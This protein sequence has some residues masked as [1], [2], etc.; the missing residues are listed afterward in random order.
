MASNSKTN[1]E[2]RPFGWSTPRLL[3]TGLVL[4]FGLTLFVGAVT[5]TAGFN[6]YNAN[7][8]GN[9][10]FRELADSQSELIVGTQTEQYD[11]VEPNATTVFILSPE[12]EY[13]T[14]ATSSVQEFVEA[15]GTVVVADNY[16]PHGN[17][18]LLEIGAAAQFDGRVLRDERHSFRSP[19]MPI[20]NNISSHQFVAGVETL[21]LNYG[22]AIE[23]QGATAIANS[24]EFGYLGRNESAT[25]DEDTELQQYPVVTIESIGEGTVVVVSDPSLFINSMLDE[26]D[27]K[28]FATTLIEQ[29]PVT[30]L[31][32]SHTTSPPLLVT[33]LL[34]VRSSPIV[35]A[36]ILSAIIGLIVIISNWYSRHD[37]PGWKQWVTKIHLTLIPSVSQSH[38]GTTQSLR[39]DKEALRA[40][41]SEQHPDWD[42]D[43]LDRVIT[44]FLSKHTNEDND[45]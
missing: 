11:T 9:S 20:A 10:E 1:I 18:L 7:W 34:L 2:W 45:E 37:T 17:E 31:D 29:R 14:T 3:L 28:E 12:H 26:P 22:T 32:Q 6:P 27:N 24:S 19:A 43:R 5:S 41:L 35:A 23:P 36:G 16:G 40:Q 15:G 21:T 8:D 13:N 44:A 39:A 30:L 33:A 4:A 42:D 25:L 38:V